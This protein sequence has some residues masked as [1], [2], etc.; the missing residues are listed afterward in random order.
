MEVVGSVDSGIHALC[1]SPDQDLVVLVTGE[2]NVLEMTQDFDTITEFQLH[3][4]EQGEG[5]HHS[6][7]WGKKETQF[8]GSAGKA[9][10]Q[11]KVD[12]SKFT[13]SEDDDMKPRVAWRGDGSFFTISDVDPNKNARVIRVYNRE[14]VLQNTS[15][16]VDKLEQAL[17]WRPSGNLIVSTQQLPHR[18]DVVFFERNGLRH[19]EFTLRETEQNKQRVLETLWNADSTILAIWVE[20]KIEGKLQKTVQL[21]TTKNYHWY[22][23]QHIVLSEGRD[24]V[25]FAWD[26]ENAMV[27]HLFSS[28]GEYHRLNYTLEVFTST[29]IDHLNSGYV[30]V[31]DGSNLLATPFVYQNV[32]PPMSSLTFTAKSDI[33][34][35]V[36]PP[37][38]SLTFTAKSDI[39]QVTFGY[40][41]AG[42]K[43]AVVTNDSIQLVELPAKGLGDVT[44]LGEYELPAITESNRSYGRNII[45]QLRWINENQLVYCQYDNELETDM[46]CVMT[47]KTNE[48]DVPTVKAIPMTSQIGRIYFNAT[49]KDLLIEDV[50]G[51]VYEVSELDQETP[52]VTKIHSFP[53]FCSWIASTIEEYANRP[54]QKIAILNVYGDHLSFKTN[55]EEAGIVYM[56][57]DNKTKAMESYRMAG[58]WREAFSI[59]K[60]LE[61]TNEEIHAL[62]YDMIEYLKEK[63]RYQE[64]ATVAKDYAMD[65]EE[66]VDCFLKGGFW[67]EAERVSYTFNRPDLIETHVK[68]GLV[69]G[70]TQTEEDIDEM[71]AQFHKQT[72]RLTELR[73]KK[74]EQKIENPMAN[75]ES[76]DNIDMFSDTTSMYSQFT[77]YTNASSRVSSVTSQ[78][79]G[80][81]RKTSK[82]RR[83]EERKRA[84]GKKGTVFE[85]EYLVGSLKKLYEKASNM[86][87]DI[88][89]L[90]RAL[91]P[92]GYV[93]EARS[94]Q[95]KFEKFLD[96][97]K[98]SMETIFVPLQLAVSL[99][100]SPEEYEEARKEPLKPVEKP[101]MAKVEWKLQIL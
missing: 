20:T 36:P 77:R 71:L 74:V 18:H 52:A 79:S 88:G 34:Q 60:Q 8:H 99:Y 1:W 70:L 78:G 101:V 26:V 16:P 12:T 49:Y 35:N 59:A 42:L 40:D 81:S 100:A 27:A 98:G 87:N 28:A 37:M 5:V 30:A 93:D 73:T 4:E 95:E 57:A 66:A 19:G 46:L 51:S 11:Q 22:M 97:L 41:D 54:S 89:N 13:I 61:Y 82:L 3:V 86:Q 76:L 50:E 17:D 2:K 9:A 64:A 96:E 85:E 38:S 43:V 68:S 55:Y 44:V 58:C 69:E 39:Q 67:K 91:V 53:D 92:F 15:E 56:M 62:A 7:G 31:I 23:K 32:P 63:R 83:K 21:W 94:I 72:T 14:G 33:Q 80:R 84:R 75:D 45:H 65:I 90:L 48:H 6:V 10:A 47:L 29:S 25:G 24:I